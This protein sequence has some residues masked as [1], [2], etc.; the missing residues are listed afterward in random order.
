MND[1][2]ND[3]VV[4]QNET[5]YDRGGNVVLATRFERLHDATGTGPLHGP[6]GTQPRA[7][8]SYLTLYHDAIGRHRFAADYGTNGGAELDRPETPPTP[9]ETVL[10][11]ETRY[12]ADGQAGCQIGPDGTI[13]QTTRNRL[14]E[15]IRTVEA[16]GTDAERTQR[17]R[18]HPSGQRSHLIL[19]NPATGE[20]VTEWT[21]GTTLETSGIARND[22]VSGKT[23]PTAESESSTFNRQS[24]IASRTDPNGSVREFQYDQ[25]GQLT[26]DAAAVLAPGVDGTMRRVSITYNDQGRPEFYTTT[27]D[28]DPGSGD[29]INQV[30]R[31]YNAFG[32]VIADQQEHDGVVDGSTPV[33]SYEYTDGSDNTLRRTAVIAPSGAQVDSTYGS[34]G[35]I[36][37]VFNQVASLK[38]NGE[39]DNLVD[40]TYAGIARVVTLTYPATGAQL[41]YLQPGGE[42]GQSDAGDSMSGYDRFNRTIRMPWKK[43]S[44]GTIL[45]DIAYG[46][47]AASR[48]KWRQDLT[49]EA[50]ASFDRFYGYDALGQVKAADRGTLNENRTAIGGIP[51]EAEAWNYDEQ[52]NWLKYLKAEDGVT[53]ID[54]HRRNNQSNQITTV[55]GS[56]VGV[57]YDRN[58]N[59]L[60]VP[61]DDAL[62]GAP[63]HLKWNAWNQ[64]VE[65]RDDEDELIQRNAYDALFGR[66]T[67][68]LNDSTLIH[69]YYNDQWR[70][71]EER[72]DS[73]TDPSAVYFW[74]ARYRDD[75]ARR[76]RD[77]DGNGTLD[78][79]LWCLMDYFDPIVVIDD[80]GEVVERYAYSAFG[81]ASFL[82]PDYS[83]RTSS[84][85]AWDFLFHGQF[86]DEETSWQNYGYRFYVPELGRWIN[87]DPIGERGGVN[88]FAMV[89]NNPIRWVDFLGRWFWD[90]DDQQEGDGTGPFK[91]TV[92]KCQIVILYGHGFWSDTNGDGEPD[93]D[94]G[95]PHEFDFGSSGK[96]AAGV[97]VGC[98][99]GTTNQHIPEENRIEGAPMSNDFLTS[100]DP[101]S[102][103]QGI[104]NVY[105]HIKGKA[106]SRADDMCLDCCKEVT[107]IIFYSFIKKNVPGDSFSGG[108]KG[109]RYQEYNCK[110]KTW[111][112]LSVG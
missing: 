57:A 24:D 92:K 47:D 30:K 38:V 35:S 14:G 52:G 28:P 95:L 91:I 41:S 36:T 76:D 23:Y 74:G 5:T 17:F 104:E 86:E 89:I 39:S 63:R 112:K 70:P 19:E 10:V 101:F 44:D 56:N 111:T 97:F 81:V 103:L 15:P 108:H 9:S 49:P 33:T 99:S 66:T 18:Y 96:C 22:L 8:R 107:L 105:N 100:G 6:H 53:E 72:V 82:A 64:L 20:Q 42:P 4:E 80:E 34:S 7:R 46:Y 106:Q 16:L 2:T 77:T 48:R 43:V 84:A 71:V 59:M 25:L 67:R 58:G 45:A 37:D 98:Y 78:E 55:D 65:V 21:F 87:R 40:Y 93:E 51:E 13:G 50:E 88:L 1:L 31:V 110:K 60:R 73:S 61:T 54:Q 94:E 29:V 32:L 90:Y 102:S 11:S 69:S 85:V 75:L 109:S 79:S 26:D 62:T 3:I 27:D 83:A 68:E 12:A